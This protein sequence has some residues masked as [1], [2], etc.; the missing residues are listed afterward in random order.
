[1]SD[2]TQQLALLSGTLRRQLKRLESGEMKVLTLLDGGSSDV[3]STESHMAQLRTCLQGICVIAEEIEQT[4]GVSLAIAPLLR[5][6]RS[7]AVSAP[8]CETSWPR[9]PRQAAHEAAAG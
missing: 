8:R 1:M 9:R 6:A 4:R 5:G 7:A 2:I 3:D